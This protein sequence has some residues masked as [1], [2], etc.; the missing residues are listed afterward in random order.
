VTHNERHRGQRPGHCEQVP[1]LRRGHRPRQPDQVPATHNE[2]AD[3]APR[4]STCDAQRAAP[5]VAA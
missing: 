1:A 4:P 3:W 2:A 5:R